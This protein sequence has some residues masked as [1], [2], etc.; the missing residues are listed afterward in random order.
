VVDLAQC[1]HVIGDKRYGHYAHF[2]NFFFGR[3]P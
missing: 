1:L 3:L 2:F